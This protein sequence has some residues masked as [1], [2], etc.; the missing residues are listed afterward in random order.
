[1]QED[2]DNTASELVYDEFEEVVARMYNIREFARRP[3]QEREVEGAL[4]TGFDA[5]LE[6]YFL[7]MALKAIAARKRAKKGSSKS[8]V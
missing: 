3:A 4:E 1:M 5:W 2:A 7:P 8:M 6:S